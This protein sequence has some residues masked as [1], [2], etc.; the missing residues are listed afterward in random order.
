MKTVPDS[1]KI[2]QI[3]AKKSKF[4]GGP[5]P[6]PPCFVMQISLP[7]PYSPTISHLA[8][9]LGQNLKETLLITLLEDA[10]EYYS[11]SLFI[12]VKKHEKKGYTVFIYIIL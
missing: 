5:C 6:G 1:T 2:H 7:P 8:P 9:P 4:S 10:T 3:K 12:F 11:L